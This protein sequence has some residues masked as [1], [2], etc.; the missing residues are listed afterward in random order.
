[1]VGGALVLARQPAR[2]K[3]RLD[4]PGALLSAAGMFSL[5]YGFGNAATHSWGDP[6][7]WGFLV[8]GTVLLALFALW[9]GR[10]ANPLLP[11]RVVL[12]RNRAGA[13]VAV[14]FAAFCLFA[15]FFL[16]TFYLQGTL[17]FSPVTA[18][19]AF[20]PMSAGLVLASNLSTIVL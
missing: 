20:L 17:G 15:T 5:V 11:P 19:L 12:N 13:Y 16:L 8:A 4:I 14:F 18:G 2:T 3:P 10:A 9:M 7:T 1:F 6:S